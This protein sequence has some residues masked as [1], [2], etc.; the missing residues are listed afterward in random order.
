MS[1]TELN[2][3][4]PLDQMHLPQPPTQTP[5]EEDG[6]TL[7]EHLIELRTR[8]V[9]A[10]IAVIIGMGLG[11]FFVLGP[12]NVMH[13]IVTT[14]TGNDGT[15]VIKP[16]QAVTATEA[17]TS[18]M[19][20]ALTFGI[21]LAMPVIVYQLIGFIAPGLTDSEKRYLFLALPFVTGFF[22]LGVAFGWFFTVPAALRFLLTFGDPNITQIQPALSD[23]ISTVTTLLLINGVVFE[24]P[25]IIYILAALRLVT[26]EWLARFRRYAMVIIIIVAALITPTG[27]PIN[28]MLLAI[29]MYLLFELGIILARLAPKRNPA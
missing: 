27:D 15:G 26:S 4:T 7:M 19:T 3:Q 13:Y 24:M 16:T 17:F 18:Y 22:L 14:L 23:F 6:M 11:A 5:E 10:G 2:R 20:V 28:L 1:T 12:P 9:K 25:I 29:P 8:L 21:I